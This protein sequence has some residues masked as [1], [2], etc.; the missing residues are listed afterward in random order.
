MRKQRK[1]NPKFFDH[2]V[3]RGNNRQDIFLDGRDVAAFF[4][5]LHYTYEKY[6]FTIIAYCIM[7]NHYHLLIR[8]PEV[9]L[10]KVMAYINRRYS[11]MFKKKYQYTGHLYESRYF[12]VMVI[13][14]RSL[15][16]VSRYI[17]RNPIDT[18]TPMVKR[19]ED[20]PYSSFYLYK[21]SSNAPYPFL[22][23]EYLPTLLYK[24]HEKTSDAYCS[25]CEEEKD[26]EVPNSEEN[27]KQ[28]ML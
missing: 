8:S 15:L 6:P 22:D 13:T 21:N 12:S 18:K 27:E 17:H 20:Y 1:W 7:N 3:M 26:S 11:E 25:Y 16:K 2:V 4:R 14:P 10:S 24:T 19:M 23:L 28:S 5:V 9:Q